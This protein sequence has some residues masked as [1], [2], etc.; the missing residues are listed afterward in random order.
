MSLKRACLPLSTRHSIRQLCIKDMV[1]HIEKGCHIADANV[2][3]LNFYFT[4]RIYVCGHESKKDG[5]REMKKMSDDE[6][7]E[8]LYGDD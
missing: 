2:T 4:K 3:A 7:W 1:I 5:V 6:V 8:A